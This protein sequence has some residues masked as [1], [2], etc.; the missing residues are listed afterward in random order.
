MSFDPSKVTSSCCKC[1]NS[2]EA[3]IQICDDCLESEIEEAKSL[4]QEFNEFERRFQELIGDGA[5]I[6]SRLKELDIYRDAE[7][8]ESYLLRRMENFLIGN[9]IFNFGSVQKQ[10]Q[11]I[12]GEEDDNNE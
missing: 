4:F 1:N 10:L 2:V 6:V 11:E 5:D 9:E 12:I 3:W 7:Q 8:M